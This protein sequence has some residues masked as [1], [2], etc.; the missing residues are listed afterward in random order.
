LS[1]HRERNHGNGHLTTTATTTWAAENVTDAPW[2]TRNACSEVASC[3]TGRVDTEEV[4]GSIPVSPTTNDLAR[5][6]L[7]SFLPGRSSLL[8]SAA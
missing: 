2:P 7:E 1:E 4:T 8:E 6:S 5:S 3:A